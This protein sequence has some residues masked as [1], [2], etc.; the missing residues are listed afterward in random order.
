MGRPFCRLSIIEW[1]GEKLENVGR[2]GIE[3]SSKDRFRIVQRRERK[4]IEF[5]EVGDIRVKE[6]RSREDI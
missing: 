5:N 6:H 3:T 2:Q 1:I 4:I